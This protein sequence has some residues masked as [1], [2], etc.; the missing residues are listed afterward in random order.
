M[1]R[2][3]KPCSD[4]RCPTVINSEIWSYPH[5]ADSSIYMQ[6]LPQIVTSRIR[7]VEYRDDIQQLIFHL[8]DLSK[9]LWMRIPEANARELRSD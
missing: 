3:Y 1:E 7:K 2:G 4:F 8:H 5:S 6:Y 9:S